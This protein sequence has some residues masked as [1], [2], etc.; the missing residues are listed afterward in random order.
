MTS[1]AVTAVAERW[2]LAVPFSIARGTVDAVDVVVVE[3][4]DG[5]VVGRGECRPYPRYGESTESVL[6]QV[7]TVEPEVA[8]G[9]DRADIVRLMPAGAARNAVDSALL[10]LEARVTGRPPWELLD[11]PPPIPR[12][13]A[14]TVGLGTPDE[15]GSAAA[16]QPSRPLLKLKLGK[17]DEDVARVAAVRAARP[18]ADLIIDANEGWTGDNLERHLDGMAEHGVLL[19]EQPLPAG[20]DEILASIAR[21]VTVCADESCHTAADLEGLVGRYDAVNIKLDKAGGPTSAAAMLRDGSRLGFEL[22]V[23]CMVGTSLAIAPAIPLAR[24]ARFVDLDAPLFLGRDRACPIHFD[25]STLLPADGALWGG[26]DA[27]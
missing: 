10:D 18:D 2:P 16:A 20:D 8:R 24:Q 15:M 3:V 9:A 22:M 14:F 26:A 11:L 6:G 25:G 27:P 1:R 17:G 13:T 19:V 4:R 7:R 5:D 21:R 12:V 23:G